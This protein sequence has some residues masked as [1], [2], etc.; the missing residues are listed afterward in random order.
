MYDSLSVEWLKTTLPKWKAKVR[1]VDADMGVGE[2]QVT[3]V[4]GSRLWWRIGEG[5]TGEGS[6]EVGHW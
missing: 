1:G 5:I 6:V 3:L 4:D 2:N